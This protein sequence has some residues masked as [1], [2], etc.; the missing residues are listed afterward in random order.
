[1]ICETKEASLAK[2]FGISRR[3]I[4]PELM[5]QP[6]LDGSKHHRA[7]IG[8]RRIN[9]LSLT[10][11]QLKL[12][13]THLLESS[14]LNR[15][16]ILELACGG[17]DVLLSLESWLNRT[18]VQEIVLEG[19]DVNPRTVRFAKNLAALRESRVRFFCL[20]A[21]DEELPEGYDIMVSSLFLHHL[22]AEENIELLGKMASAAKVGFVVSDLERSW[23]GLAAA[24]TGVH[25]LSRSPVVHNDGV[26]SVRASFRKKELSD[27]AIAAGLESFT[28][29]R[30]WPFRLL[31]VYRKAS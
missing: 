30:C 3:V 14:K 21:V 5:D 9:K 10:A 1:V 25:L 31:L 20:N 4:L 12:A 22:T 15:A 26:R 28:V 6:D 13:V 8:L 16:R 23:L 11:F 2:Q 29:S 7:L 18:G 24:C 19:C 17:G 27:L